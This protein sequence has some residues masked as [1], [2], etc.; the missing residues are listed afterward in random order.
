MTRP[1]VEIFSKYHRRPL[2]ALKA[3]RENLEKLTPGHEIDRKTIQKRQKE[4]LDLSARLEDR[5][6]WGPDAPLTVILLGATGTGK[7]KLFNSLAGQ[8][9]S[10]SGFKRPTTMSPVLYIPKSRVSGVNR[11]TF[12]PGYAKRTAASAPVSFSLSDGLELVIFSAENPR[13]GD[14]ILIDTPDFDSVIDRNREA[15]K[16]VLERADAVIFVTDAIKYADQAAWDH[17]D[18]IRV[19][20]K[21]AILVVNRVKNPL[22]TEDFSRR[23]KA[24]G[25]NR[26]ILS[27]A[28]QPGLGDSDLF[29]FSDPALKTIQ[30]QLGAWSLDQRVDVLAH[31]ALADWQ[32]LKSGLFD[33]LLPELTKATAS[34][35]ELYIDVEKASNV[36]V[37]GLKTQLGSAISSELKNSLLSRIQSLFLRWD[38]MKYPRKVLMLPFNLIKAKVL[39]PLGVTAF[40]GLGDLDKEIDGLFETNRETLV[41]A[42]HEFNRQIGDRF[43][44]S[45]AGR[46]LSENPDFDAAPM[47]GDEVRDAY[48][49]VRKELEVWVEEQAK[50]L[51]QGLGLGEKMTFYLAQA[52]SLGLFISIQVHTGGG[53]S[54]FDGLLDSVLAPFLSKL[55][56]HA[57]SRDK[58]KAFEA[59]ASQKHLDG[60][61]RIIQTQADRYFEI[62]KSADHGLA[63]RDRI[64]FEAAELASVFKDWT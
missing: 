63:A 23:L 28:D 59:A 35:G 18:R 9:V 13:F 31:E 41:S 12:F 64:A 49:K 62:I 3:L 29:P 56:G 57:L 44:A 54:F 55:T 15:A 22:S 40:S 50:E 2:P 45:S 48:A 34:L 21:E 19:R 38:I 53:F 7:S 51:V 39:T 24:S 37:E 27:I 33:R 61:G 52:I 47:S 32:E 36:M 30:E 10:P 11:P 60:G 43:T 42:V 46:G 4:L 26:K 1:L 8:A 16:E 17:L 14:L 58:V 25:L 5:L 20:G 6:D